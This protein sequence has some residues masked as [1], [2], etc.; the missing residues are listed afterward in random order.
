MDNKHKQI[1]TGSTVLIRGAVI[2]PLFCYLSNFRLYNIPFSY[3][4]I[5]CE[6][7]KK[8]YLYSK[9]YTYNK[10][11]VKSTPATTVAERM[12]LFVR[13]EAKTRA[14]KKSRKKSPKKK[15]TNEWI[16]KVM[17]RKW[18]SRFADKRK[19]WLQQRE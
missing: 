10:G 19:H 18:N 16:P 7:P 14:E 13:R 11:K 4:N 5:T 9:K 1:G 12:G 17:W 2:F 3:C 6:R 8:Q 15:R